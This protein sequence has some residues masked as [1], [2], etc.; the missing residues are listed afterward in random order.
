MLLQ[1]LNKEPVVSFWGGKDGGI[2]NPEV[3]LSS[4]K[5]Y[6]AYVQLLNLFVILHS[7]GS[8]YT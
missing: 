2:E 7:M 5:G 4:L 6:T 3:E 1:L 8:N